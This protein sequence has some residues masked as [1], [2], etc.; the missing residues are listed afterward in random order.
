MADLFF[1][2][3]GVSKADLEDQTLSGKKSK[4]KLDRTLV[5]MYETPNP[6]DADI[7]NLEAI[8]GT[9]PADYSAFLKNNNGG[10]PNLPILKTKTNE[11]VINSFLAL[12]APKEFY[13]SIFHTL[14]IY[15][16]RIP[17][18]TL[19]I[20]STGSGDLLLLSVDSQKPGEIFYWDHNFES[21]EDDARDYVDNIELV[22]PS[23]SALLTKL[24]PDL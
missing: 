14:K 3:L 16:L 8:T 15:G 24:L 20:A 9:L 5:A 13:D 22:A 19:P 11:R 1:K 23:F 10:I 12:N 6:S 21:D 17:K 7:A 18:D 4:G 2:K